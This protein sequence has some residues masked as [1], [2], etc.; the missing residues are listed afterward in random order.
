[1]I[2]EHGWSIL[3]AI[4]TYYSII[5]FLLAVS[6]FLETISRLGTV[7]NTHSKSRASK[8]KCS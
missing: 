6:F 5:W 1:M 3:M 4:N 8:F 7:L 2:R